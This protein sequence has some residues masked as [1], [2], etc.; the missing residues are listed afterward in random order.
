MT[1]FLH[2]SVL[3]V[4][5]G[6]LEIA[7]GCLALA[8]P[9]SF[10][11]AYPE[12]ITRLVRYAMA[13]VTGGV[14]V[15]LSF[16]ARNRLPGPLAVG[17]AVLGALPLV[18][19]SAALIARAGLWLAPITGLALGLGVIADAF[20]RAD[21][22]ADE[23]Q[24]AGP[25]PTL[26]PVVAAVTAVF[27]AQALL[28]PHTL[29][30]PP[31]SWL[32]AAR[33]P[34]GAALVAGAAVL[35]VGWVVPRLRAA[36]QVLG[37]L[38]LLVVAAGLVPV[39]RWPGTLAYGLLGVALAAEPVLHR[40]LRRRIEERAEEP[41]AIADY[42][43][44]TE[45]AAWGFVVLIALAGS[46]GTDVENRL[47]LAVLALATSLFTIYWFHVRSVRG[48][49]LS[50]TVTGVSIY[51]FLVA[52]LVALTGGMRS[53]YFFVYTLP[54]IALAWTRAPQT[55]IV[56]LA[57]PLAAVLTE[58]VLA[59]TGRVEPAG[60]LAAVAAPRL[61]GLLLVTGFSYLM[62]QRNLGEQRRVRAAHLQLQTVVE[63]MAEG[64]VT[65]DAGGRVTLCNAAAAALLGAPAQVAGRRLGDLL[66]LQQPDGAPLGPRDQPLHRGL[67]G[68]RVPWQRAR[69]VTATGATPIEVA[70]SPLLDAHGP[71]GA[72][73]LLRDVRAEVEMERLRDDFFFI[74]S[75]ELR[76]P[77]TVM[78]GN[79]ELALETA[80]DPGLRKT[81]EEALASVARLIRM[82][83]D[84]LD[85]A[86]LEQGSIT[87]RVEDVALPDLVRQAVETLRADADRKGIGLVYRPAALPLVRADAERTL[88]ILL[89]LLG[90]SVRYT[91]EGRVEVWHE[92]RDATVLT[93]VRDT[94][95]GIAAEHH[96]RLFTRFGQVERGLTRTSGGS[97]LGLYISRKLAEGMGGSVALVRSAP[98][99]GSTFAL[100]LPVATDG[101]SPAAG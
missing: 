79:L 59:W 6:I 29:R 14:L 24:A 100:V 77:L 76:T 43:V 80:A 54:I 2:P 36:S 92:V 66:V 37:A 11:A 48:A 60:V 71:G 95:P 30:V 16:A 12:M 101:A 73:V 18:V 4:V 62:A 51:S 65:V 90:N 93:Y 78:K 5:V 35:A 42:E 72:V 8:A 74:A 28:A 33:E 41:R 87:M 22:E 86:R 46:V 15:L 70:V 23:V 20:R 7:L 68:Q 17:L 25:V 45:S 19:M 61:A 82:V 53:P 52:L 26:A 69:A 85:A 97:G 44:A 47:A 64:L 89:N 83:N 38:P 3:P 63:N 34:L 67:A 50:R 96:D 40:L 58:T 39:G 10:E 13:F 27:G 56:P 31:A 91:T 94:G 75:H 98:G 21:P 99:E 32:G 9:H 57:I 88:Q 84:F 49:G 55:I 1:A 81:I